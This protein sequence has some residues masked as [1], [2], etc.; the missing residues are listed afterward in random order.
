MSDYDYHTGTDNRLRR[1]AAGEVQ[2]EI[3]RIKH[4]GLYE[5]YPGDLR[6]T[7]GRINAATSNDEIRSLLD[8]ARNQSGQVSDKPHHSMWTQKIFDD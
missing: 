1:K 8:S 7:L 3:D 5:R 2:G 6:H 4:E